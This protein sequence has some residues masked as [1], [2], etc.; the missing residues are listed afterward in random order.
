MAFMTMGYNCT[1]FNFIS[2]SGSIITDLWLP[3][4]NTIHQN[5]AIVG[6]LM[7]IPFI[8]CIITNP[9]V[10]KFIDGRG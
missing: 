2:F 6:G 10:G 4:T 5:Q 8:V 7:G 1:L 9:L 3:S